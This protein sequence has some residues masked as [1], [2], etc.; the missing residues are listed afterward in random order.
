MKLKRAFIILPLKVEYRR[1]IHY[2]K[3]LLITS[4]KNKKI[5]IKRMSNKSVDRT[6]M[7]HEGYMTLF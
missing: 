4:P 5:I 6:C 1:Y 2:S 3:T 7:K